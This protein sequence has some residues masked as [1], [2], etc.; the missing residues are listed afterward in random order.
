MAGKVDLFADRLDQRDVEKLM[1]DSLAFTAD[2]SPAICLATHDEPAAV[3]REGRPLHTLPSKVM[4]DQ[5]VK[6]QT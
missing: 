6:I 4:I 3:G 2:C 5:S 1:L